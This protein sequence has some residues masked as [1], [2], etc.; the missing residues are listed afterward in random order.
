MA[1]TSTALLKRVSTDLCRQ[2]ITN[3]PARHWG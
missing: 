1:T 3:A 2:E